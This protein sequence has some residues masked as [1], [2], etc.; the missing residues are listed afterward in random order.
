MD[1]I[2]CRI[3]KAE[4]YSELPQ[5]CVPC[6]KKRIKCKQTRTNSFSCCHCARFKLHCHYQAKNSP[7]VRSCD[8]C[9]RAKKK[10]ETI[11]GG[12]SRCA[13]CVHLKFPCEKS[14]SNSN[15]SIMEAWGQSGPLDLISSQPSHVSCHDLSQGNRISFACDED[16]TNMALNETYTA[17]ECCILPHLGTTTPPKALL[18]SNTKHFDR[19]VLIIVAFHARAAI[20]S[21]VYAPNTPHE[22][23]PI[24]HLYEKVLHCLGVNGCRT[25]LIDWSN[26]VGKTKNSKYIC[27]PR[28][29]PAYINYETPRNIP[30]KDLKKI[31][32]A[33]LLP[34]DFDQVR[35]LQL[36]QSV[37]SS[38]ICEKGKVLLK[39]IFYL[40]KLGHHG[41]IME[42]PTLEFQSS[43]FQ[44]LRSYLSSREEKRSV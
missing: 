18:R 43:S 44:R 16:S 8:N 42:E 33:L 35:F 31:L 20:I 21:A 7:T 28:W 36:Y 14:L 6:Q 22:S 17:A 10:C 41:L 4:M 25:L 5:A 39:Y 40:E 34:D 9:R 23:T 12:Q 26:A 2:S 29:W 38:K 30:F 27:R 3:S 13:R 15:M 1:S 11:I 19:H 24:K 32:I 37:K